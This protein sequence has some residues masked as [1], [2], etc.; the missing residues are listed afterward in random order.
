VG[1][2]QLGQ[3]PVSPQLAG[4]DRYCLWQVRKGRIDSSGRDT[5]YSSPVLEIDGKLVS[6]NDLD[7]GPDIVCK[8]GLDF[9]ENCHENGEPFLLYYPMI[10]THC[11]FSP[12]PASPEWH[13]DDT[14]IMSYKGEARYF[15]DMVAQMDHLV[16]KIVNKLEELGIQNNTLVIF[17]GDN[18]TD[19]PVVS[20]MND[21]MIAGAKGKTTDA[22]TRVPLVVKWPAVIQPQTINSDLVD[23][24]DFLPTL[25]EAVNINLDSME[26]DGRSFL[27]QLRG[28]KGNPRE[29]IYSWFSR[30]G[31]LGEARVFARN[32][33][34]KL[35]DTGE[36]YEIPVDY[37]EENPLEIAT[38]DSATSGVYQQLHEV[39]L[40]YGKRR[41]DKVQSLTYD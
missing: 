31:E 36:L 12:T 39:L 14:T 26:L 21:R 34:F 33:R 24:T 35:Y 23:F 27:P 41:L 2:W 29:W 1:K 22:G 11:P 28:E 20:R 15:S 30:N 32:H 9:I 37:M 16:G 4:F 17:T 25:A 19:V 40:Y 8:F 5:R 13:T 6:Y 7:Y 3:D 38:L 10:L 18:G